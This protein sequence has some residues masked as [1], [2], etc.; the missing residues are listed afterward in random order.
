MPLTTSQAKA[1]AWRLRV[2]EYGARAP[3]FCGN[4]REQTKETGFPR[5]PSE[6]CCSYRNLQTSPE[7]SGSL[8]HNVMN[9]EILY[10]S[11]LLALQRDAAAQRVTCTR[12]RL[13]AGACCCERGS[14]AAALHNVNYPEERCTCCRFG[15]VLAYTNY[16]LRSMALALDLASASELAL[17]VAAALAL[18]SFTGQEKGNRKRGSNH[19]ITYKS[20]LG[21]F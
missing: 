21:H 2:L 4:L 7:T 15:R 13:R 10:C 1:A 6:I 16:P 14:D 5:I 11:S 9:L 3:A 19:E 20:L 8:R 17:T 12:G 18:A